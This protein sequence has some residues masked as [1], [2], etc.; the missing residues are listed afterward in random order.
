MIQMLQTR[1]PLS[2]IPGMDGRSMTDALRLLERSMFDIGAQVMPQ[3]DRV[4]PVALRNSAKS[5]IIRI[6]CATYDQL[7]GAITDPKNRYECPEVIVTYRPQQFA[8]VVGQQQ[9]PPSPSK[10]SPASP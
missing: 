10:A 3:C 2:E 5:Q 8:S 1:K 7:Y 4:Q 6:I 9:Q